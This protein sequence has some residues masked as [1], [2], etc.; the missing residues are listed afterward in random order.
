MDNKIFINIV[1]AHI[2]CYNIRNCILFYIMI[3]IRKF[4]T[5]Y[6]LIYKFNDCRL[7]SVFSL[8]KENYKFQ[9][10]VDV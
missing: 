9:L 3:Y 8:L 10:W 2:S 4:N 1:Y 7:T 6:A 5:T